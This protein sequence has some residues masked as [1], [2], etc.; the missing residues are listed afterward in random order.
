MQGMWYSCCCLT[1]Y[2]V[3]ICIVAFPSFCQSHKIISPCWTILKEFRVCDGLALLRST[4][5]IEIRCDNWHM[6][7]VIRIY[8][9]KPFFVVSL[10]HAEGLKIN[11]LFSF[12]PF[13]WTS[14]FQSENHNMLS[15]MII[16]LCYLMNLEFIFH[17]LPIEEDCLINIVLAI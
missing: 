9:R 16:H 11:M 12:S 6:T 5:L 15:V 17:T 3:R 8:S 13:C 7:Q 10:P 4:N 14:R 1:L 2:L